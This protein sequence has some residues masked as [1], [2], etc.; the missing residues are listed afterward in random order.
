V[1]DIRAIGL[2]SAIELVKDRR[3]REP[4]A[5]WNGP[6][7]GIMAKIGAC[8]KEKGVYVYLRWNYM[9]IAPPIAINEEELKFGLDAVDKCLALADETL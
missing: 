3:S 6:D 1:G 7:P 4:L 8:L 5:P 2:F 9:F